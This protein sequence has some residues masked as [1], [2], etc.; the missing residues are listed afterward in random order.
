MNK[1][2]LLLI[3]L[4]LITSIE[5]EIVDRIVAKVGKE[6]I[7]E[8]EL[9]TRIQQM[10]AA[11][12]M[13]ESVSKFDILQSMIES[14][15]IV[16]KAKEEGFVVD[17]IEVRTLADNQMQQ[18]ISQFPTEEDFRKQ[19]KQE[20]GLTAPELREFYIELITETNLREQLINEKIKNKVHVTEGE[21]E[22][23]YQ[24][25]LEE[26]PIRPAKDKLGM[27]MREIKV[28]E[29]SKEKGLI[30][31]NKIM[32]RLNDGEDF[33][34]IISGFESDDPFFTG[35]DL[36]WFGKGMMVQDF[37]DA[38]FSLRTGEIS[39]VVETRFGFHIIKLEEKRIDEVHASH[40]L[41]QLIPSEQ[42]IQTTI[43]LME[44]IHTRLE[45]GEDFSTLA[46]EYSDDIETAENEGII[47][48]FSADE[49]PSLFEEYFADLDYNEYS[50]LVREDGV[51]YIFAKLEKVPE[52][53]YTYSEIYDRLKEMVIS[54]KEQQIYDDLVTEITKETYIETYLED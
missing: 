36:G 51:I 9:D 53:Q 44:E 4:L 7:L 46:E 41:Y 43:D 48:E 14:K 37:E 45:N 52:R 15:V 3:G 17:L 42:D 33:Y 24:E 49:Y 54:Q 28:S 26:I 19:L 5:A 47:G 8:S 23:F 18:I 2:L 50:D 38:A 32:D 21:I 34:D 12:L 30:E 11:G 20:M 10:E 25:N 16:Q 27:I 13:D 40:I 1:I 6:I 29:Q 35:G 22:S 31:I 39:E